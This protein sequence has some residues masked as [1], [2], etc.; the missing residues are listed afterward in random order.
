MNIP[1]L[2]LNLFSN[3]WYMFAPFYAI[4]AIAILSS[5]VYLVA[6]IIGKRSVYVAPERHVTVLYPA[7][8]VATKQ[9]TYDVHSSSH[10][11]ALAYPASLVCMTDENKLDLAAYTVACYE[12]NI[13]A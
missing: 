8:M 13:P 4:L 7:S 10:V 3:E 5:L 12:S 2:T 1:A 9:S 11:L 6:F